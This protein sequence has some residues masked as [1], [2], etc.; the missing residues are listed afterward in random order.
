MQNKVYNVN[1]F[2]E[3]FDIESYSFWFFHYDKYKGQGEVLYKT[4]N[5]LNTFLQTVS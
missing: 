5:L 1:Y 4:K 2:R 3:Q